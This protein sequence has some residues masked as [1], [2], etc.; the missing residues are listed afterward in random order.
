MFKFTLEETFND[1]QDYYPAIQYISDGKTEEVSVRLI[2]IIESDAGGLKELN[3]ADLNI[4]TITIKFHDNTREHGVSLQNGIEP[5]RR[6]G[7]AISPMI[8]EISAT[9]KEES[10]ASA[11]A[12]MMS[13]IENNEIV[14]DQIIRTQEQIANAAR[15]RYRELLALRDSIFDPDGTCD[16]TFLHIMMLQVGADS[17]NYQLDKTHQS[18]NGNALSNCRIDRVENNNDT[19]SVLSEDM[20]RH[21]VFT[22]DE[23]QGLWYVEKPAQAFDL[24]QVADDNGTLYY[25]TYFV[26]IKCAIH[27]SRSAVWVCEQTQHKVNEDSEY[28]YFNWGILN[29][30][31]EGHYTLTETRGN[32]YNGN[33]E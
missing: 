14:G 24:A 30:D 17:M 28:Y 23:P 9:V 8:R 11:W 16:Q 22:E 20:L 6:V 1:S 21:Y 15:R 10:R 13:R 27:D 12:Q 3:Y 18:A 19:F 25:P 7:N 32:A 33:G 29:P 5:S 26:A 2:S 31:N 4:D